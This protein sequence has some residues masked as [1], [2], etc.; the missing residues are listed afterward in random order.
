MYSSH[1]AYAQASLQKR[2]EFAKS[3]SGIQ[4]DGC[5]LVRKCPGICPGRMEN[6][7]FF[8]W[9]FASALCP[10]P[11][12]LGKCLGRI[13]SGLGKRLGMGQN[14]C[15]YSFISNPGLKLSR[16]NNWDKKRDRN[17]ARN[18]KPGTET[19]PR[20]KLGHKA[21]LELGQ[22]TNLGQKLGH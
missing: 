20:R 21:R 3:G 10:R 1:Q 6:G 12:C 13:E 11:K 16:G 14:P 9:A 7:N 22:L 18:Q 4:L 5:V 19:Q 17:W 8:A 15:Q 2:E